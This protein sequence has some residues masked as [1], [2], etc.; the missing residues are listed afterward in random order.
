ML[1][2]YT[3]PTTGVETN[4]LIRRS[5]NVTLLDVG[6]LVGVHVLDFIARLVICR[7]TASLHFTNDSDAFAGSGLRA[8]CILLDGGS[9]GHVSVSYRK[10]L[11]HTADR[12]VTNFVSFFVT[13]MH[14]CRWSRW[15]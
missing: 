10:R 4:G 11:H 9:I 3:S 14:W 13:R 6:A 2:Q 15:V 1:S 8:Y 7:A 12:L 5:L